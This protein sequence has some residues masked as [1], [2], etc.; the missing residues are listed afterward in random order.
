MSTEPKVAVSDAEIQA[1]E[2]QV[3]STEQT[4]IKAVEDRV[5]KEVESEHRAKELEAKL[6]QQTKEAEAARE[7]A[8]KARA[9][10][11]ALIKQQAEQRL[12]SEES[13]SKVPVN[14]ANPF[15]EAVEKQSIDPGHVAEIGKA[16]YD[17]FLKATNRPR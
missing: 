8:T 12:R 14:G 10:A 17:A 1:V 15:K 3:K 9:D 16:S 7:E 4:A 2:N 5:R 13:R 11:D 6:A